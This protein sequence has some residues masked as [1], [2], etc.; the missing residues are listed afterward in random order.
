[1][2]GSTLSISEHP[3]KKP[4]AS[5]RV[6]PAASRRPR[7]RRPRRRRARRTTGTRSRCS[8]VMSGPIIDVSSS[9]GPTTTSGI[10]AAIASTSGS[11]T[12]PDRDHDRD[13]HAALTRRAVP[14]RDGGVGGGV[15]VGVGEH[16]HVVLRTTERLHPLAVLGAG[17]VDVARDRGA[18]DERDGIDVGVREQRVDR[19]GVALH[20]GEHA[21][22]E[23]G[24]AAPARPAAATPTG[25]S[26]TA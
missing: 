23:P 4:S 24:L 10:R 8:R 25:P 18:A 9:P 16:D 1:M 13:R 3:T 7:P 20:H 11:A 14:G 26:P 19:L 22:G 21:V 15:D 5:R 2:P 17:L 6:R 12:A